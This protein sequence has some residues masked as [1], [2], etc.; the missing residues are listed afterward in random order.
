MKYLITGSAGFIGYHLSRRFCE[1][2]IEVT[3]VD[4]VNSY[5]DLKLKEDRLD[6][7]KK[8]KNF[9]F[10]KSDL[11]DKEELIKIFEKEKIENVINLAAQPGVRYSITN[12]DVSIRA[13]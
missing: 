7:L 11:A 1:E 3:G 8:Y 12:P 2:G 9:K 4:N 5:Y 13:T 10:I 6:N